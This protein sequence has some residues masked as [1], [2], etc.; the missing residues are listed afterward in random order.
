MVRSSLL[1]PSLPALVEH[2]VDFRQDDL[3]SLARQHL[4]S[5]LEQSLEVELTRYLGG[6]PRYGRKASGQDYRNGS[7]TRDLA[8]GF[9]L[10]ADLQ[11]PRC[12]NGGFQTQLFERY[13][14]R[15]RQVDDFIRGLFFL[16]VSTRGVAEAVEI[17]LGITPSASA[18]SG[19]VAQLDGEVKAFHERPLEDS[20]QYLFLDGIT[21][22]VQQAPHAG[23]RLVLVAYGITSEGQ[24]V[25]VD[26]RV[27]R[28]ES[29]EEWEHFL[30][31]LY[32]RGLK[33]TQLKLIT[34]DGGKGAHRAVELVYGDV[35]RQLCWVHK[36]RNV[37]THLKVAQKPLCLGQAKSIYQARNRREARKAWKAWKER[38][39]GE[40]P[41]A[42]AC[43]ER[44][45]E[46]LLTFLECPRKHHRYLRTTNYIERLFREVRQRTRV[47]GAFANKASCDR[48]LYGV[49]D[50]VTRRW[51][52][53]TLA[54][55]THNS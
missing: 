38:W 36:L 55:F 50:R 25:L 26:Y 2:A 44:D 43:L 30:S 49:L 11:V 21:L 54:G 23:K 13:Q 47:M 48:L 51:S 46:S 33:G 12:R 16:G 4:K 3:L 20:L 39:Q 10:L 34:T 14:R 17:L 45:L 22:T 6:R 53:R 35:D 52:A 7:Y 27:A 18:V 29:A 37:E 15:H 24:R 42:V 40:A 32:R 41:Q 5:L 28:S 1:G 31:D 19:I 8:T 9:G